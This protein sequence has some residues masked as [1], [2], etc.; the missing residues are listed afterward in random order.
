MALRRQHLASAPNLG[1]HLFLCLNL[2]L[3]P[4]P[5][6]ECVGGELAPEASGH[7]HSGA[8]YAHLNSIKRLRCSLIRGT[9]LG[10][11]ARLPLLVIV[12]GNQVQSPRAG[13]HVGLGL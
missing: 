8:S 5:R 6:G 3:K 12:R 11:R 7:K 1:F 2:R 13:A 10:Y 9:K 4:V